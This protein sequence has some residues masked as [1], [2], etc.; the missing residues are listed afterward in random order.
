MSGRELLTEW[1]MSRFRLAPAALSLLSLAA[2]GCAAS[3]RPAPHVLSAA[4]GAECARIGPVEGTGTGGSRTTHETQVYWA[5]QDAL[6]TA[7]A[8]GATHVVLDSERDEATG[9]RL[10]GFGYR[11]P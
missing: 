1:N 4:S 3:L 7:K 11:C 10:S 8:M 2:S 5:T 6:N 9:V